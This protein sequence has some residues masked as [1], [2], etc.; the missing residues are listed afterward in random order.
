MAGIRRRRGLWT[1][2]S[3]TAQFRSMTIGVLALR[4]RSSETIEAGCRSTSY[5]QIQLCRRFRS[6]F[7]A[8]SG[9]RAKAKGRAP[10]RDLAPAFRFFEDLVRG[11]DHT[12]CHSGGCSVLAGLRPPFPYSSVIP[13]AVRAFSCHPSA[14]SFLSASVSSIADSLE[15]RC[16]F[17]RVSLSV[18]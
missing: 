7:I 9:N 1:Y 18:L 13:S 2:H 16:R 17:S 5:L 3:R 8:S 11:P 10:F 14:F 12:D 6:R 15:Y 4:R